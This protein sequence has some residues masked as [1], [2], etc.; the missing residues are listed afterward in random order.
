MYRVK[1]SFFVACVVLLACFGLVDKYWNIIALISF[2]ELLAVL[3]EAFVSAETL[4]EF[5][6]EYHD[7]LPIEDTE[8]D[9]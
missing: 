4:E 1:L 8:N 5:E 7:P 2:C 9:S 6:V 3:K